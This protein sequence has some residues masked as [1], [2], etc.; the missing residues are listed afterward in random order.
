MDAADRRVFEK[1]LLAHYLH[2]DSWDGQKYRQTQ[3]RCLGWLLDARE[4]RTLAYLQYEYLRGR[5]AEFIPF[6]CE[7]LGLPYDG[8]ADASADGSSGFSGSSD[9]SPGGSTGSPGSTGSTRSTRSTKEVLLRRYGALAA[10]ALAAARA[11]GG[12]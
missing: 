1:I 3:E 2:L 9:G 11:R 5:D 10:G 7:T 12:Y 4:T 8:T 6:L